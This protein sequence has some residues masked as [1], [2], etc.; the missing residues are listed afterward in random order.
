MDRETETN[1]QTDRDR[2]TD[3]GTQAKTKTDRMGGGEGGGVY[4]GLPMNDIE[5]IFQ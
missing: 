5:V 4:Y 2:Q 3:R 1:R